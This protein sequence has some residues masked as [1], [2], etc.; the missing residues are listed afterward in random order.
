M[1]R[2][3]IV[4]VDANW[5]T[6]PDSVNYQLVNIAIHTSKQRCDTFLAGMAMICRVF[7]FSLLVT[8]GLS[9]VG[10]EEREGFCL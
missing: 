3:V 5:I 2:S 8:S 10:L 4:L 6:R 9:G 7:W 1:S